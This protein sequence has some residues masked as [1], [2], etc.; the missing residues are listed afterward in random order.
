VVHKLEAILIM[1]IYFSRLAGNPEE[2]VNSL[3]SVNR[4]KT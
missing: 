4:W 3:L 1:Q 2:T